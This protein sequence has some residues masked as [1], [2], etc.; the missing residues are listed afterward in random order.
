V[1]VAAVKKAVDNAATEERAAEEAI[2]QGA[3]EVEVME[4]A[5]EELVGSG[6]SPA[7]GAGTKR[8]TEKPSGQFLSLIV[9]SH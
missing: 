9:M 7:L 2:T 5:A 1:D 3:I 8:A 4:K 6:S